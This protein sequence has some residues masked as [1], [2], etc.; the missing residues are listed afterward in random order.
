MDKR[1][2][3]TDKDHERFI[4]CHRLML[5]RYLDGTAG[6]PDKEPDASGYIDSVLQ[7]WQEA[8][9]GSELTGPSPQERTFWFALYLLE[10]LVENPG[11][12]IEP[13]EKVMMENLIQAREL[14]RGRQAIAEHGHMATRPNGT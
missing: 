6:R 3:A 14:L 1:K 10:D 11:S 4:E 13:Y 8:F 9:S 2:E 7:E 5:L 12:N